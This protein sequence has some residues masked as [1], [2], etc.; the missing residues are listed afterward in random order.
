MTTIALPAWR[1]ACTAHKLPVRLIPRD[2]KTR[3]NSTYDMVKLAFKFRPAIDDITADKS[4]KLRKYELDDDDWKVIGD[5][6]Q[7]LKVCF[8]STAVVFWP[9]V[10][11]LCKIYKDATLFFS[12]DQVSSIANVIPTMD[13]INALLT[14]APVEPLSP[15]VKIALKFACKSINK[16]YSKTDLS[17]VYRIA[18]GMFLVISLSF[19]LNLF[20]FSVL[21]PQLKLKYFQQRSWP[22]DWI[23]TA[24]TIVREEYAKYDARSTMGPILVCPCN[25]LNVMYLLCDDSQCPLTMTLMLPLTSSTFQWMV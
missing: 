21:H 3:W 20:H 11:L 24:E 4:L 25:H 22:K 2:V 6:I 12:Q 10:D 5:L 23:N 15:S 18:M 7:V 1:K 16:Y 8:S 9:G 13:R 19:V 14:D 17:N